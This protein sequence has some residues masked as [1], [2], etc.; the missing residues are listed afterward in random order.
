MHRCPCLCFFFFFHF[1]LN[2]LTFFSWPFLSP[3][4]FFIPTR[5]GCRTKTETG[6]MDYVCILFDSG[7]FR[8]YTGGR[9]WGWDR[10]DRIFPRI[11]ACNALQVYRSI[12]LTHT[13]WSNDRSNPN[14]LYQ[15]SKCSTVPFL[16]IP[17]GVL[18]K[19]LH[20]NTSSMG[21]GWFDLMVYSQTT[22]NGNWQNGSSRLKLW[23]S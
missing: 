20:N 9:H 16:A 18:P 12:L 3:S 19:Q 11:N 17:F 4:S 13:T 23:Y 15:K 1:R 22:R 14:I 2:G 21:T 10:W 7:S 8:G 5:L 6:H